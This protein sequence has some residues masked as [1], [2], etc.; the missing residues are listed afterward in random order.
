MSDIGMPK[1]PGAALSAGLPTTSGPSSEAVINALPLPVI[2]I[3]SDD[4]ILHVNHAAELFFD[5]SAR[6]MQ[7]QRL[8]ERTIHRLEA[9]EMANPIGFPQPLQ[10]YGGRPS[11]VAEPQ[12]R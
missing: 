4:R 5:H 7:R 11:V 8:G 2:T 6:V 3:G 12:D 9:A 10:P 1:R